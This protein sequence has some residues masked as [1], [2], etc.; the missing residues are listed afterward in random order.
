MSI[1]YTYSSVSFKY[2]CNLEGLKKVTNIV[3]E[4]NKNNN[5]R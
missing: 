1:K 2:L 5:N 4:P 3:E